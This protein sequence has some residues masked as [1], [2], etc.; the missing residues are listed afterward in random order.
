MGVLIQFFIFFSVLGERG[1]VRGVK[2]GRGG[3][4]VMCVWSRR[5]R[6]G[7]VVFAGL[8]LIL[9]LPRLINQ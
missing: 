6:L 7:W 8:Y 1:E 5:E 3:G 4:D 9:I 2:E